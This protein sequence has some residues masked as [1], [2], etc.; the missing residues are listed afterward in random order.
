MRELTI[1]IIEIVWQATDDDAP[2]DETMKQIEVLIIA[3]VDQIAARRAGCTHKYPA[4]GQGSN[5]DK[6]Q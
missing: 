2:I 5:H 6:P 4:A 1:K 3:H